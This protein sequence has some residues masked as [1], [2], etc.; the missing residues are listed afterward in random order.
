MGFGLYLGSVHELRRGRVHCTCFREPVCFHIGDP[1][2]RL[3]EERRSG[4]CDDQVPSSSDCC[5]LLT[6]KIARISC[7]V[8]LRFLRT[9]FRRSVD[10]PIQSRHETV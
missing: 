8:F 7:S 5:R 4:V 9:K 6:F 3:R 10:V 1:E 2:Q